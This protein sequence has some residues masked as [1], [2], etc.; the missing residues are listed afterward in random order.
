MFFTLFI[1]YYKLRP[2]S[3]LHFTTDNYIPCDW[4]K[5]CPG[6]PSQILALPASPYNIVKSVY[7]EHFNN[8][9]IGE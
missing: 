2:K 9:Y 4:Q 7:M 6:H 1:K 8:F 3:K 5:A